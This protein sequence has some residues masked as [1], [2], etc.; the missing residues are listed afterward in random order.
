LRGAAHRLTINKVESDERAKLDKEDFE[1]PSKDQNPVDKEM[2]P[3]EDDFDSSNQLDWNCSLEDNLWWNG[4]YVPKMDIS[5]IFKP[6]LISGQIL[7]THGDTLRHLALM[8]KGHH[9]Q[10]LI[11]RRLKVLHF[12]DFIQLTYLEIDVMI[13]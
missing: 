3:R 1:E 13:L 6:A 2:K 4:Y 8:I 5:Q 7:S 12:E 11:P 10:S 9:Y